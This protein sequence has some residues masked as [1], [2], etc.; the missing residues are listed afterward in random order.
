M[1]T[2]MNQPSARPTRKV[3]VGGAGGLGIG[4]PLGTIASFYLA[5]IDPGMTVE[6]Q[7]AVAAVVAVLVTAAVS[8]L[9]RDR[10]A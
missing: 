9:V 5:R 1:A 4:V 3:A 6:I 8:Y 7:N 10:T 2:L